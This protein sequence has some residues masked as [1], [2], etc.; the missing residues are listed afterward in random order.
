VKFGLFG[1]NFGLCG[2]PR[3]AFVL[4]TD[5]AEFNRSVFEGLGVQVRSVVPPNVPDHIEAFTPQRLTE[6]LENKAK[7]G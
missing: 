4:A 5:Y 3:E 6:A 1:I 7:N 2:D